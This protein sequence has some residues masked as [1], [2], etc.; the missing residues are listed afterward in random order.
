MPLQAGQQF[1]HMAPVGGAEAEA[2]A[3][4]LCQDPCRAVLG[5]THVTYPATGQP[6]DLARMPLREHVEQGNLTW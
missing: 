5:V 1:Q 6:A 4:S 2:A 3:K